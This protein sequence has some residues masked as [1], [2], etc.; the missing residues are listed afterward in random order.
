MTVE[1][2][3]KRDRWT[4]PETFTRGPDKQSKCYIRLRRRLQDVIDVQP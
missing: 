3:R 1:Q 2:L 4:N